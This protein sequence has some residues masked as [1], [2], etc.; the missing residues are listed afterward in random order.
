MAYQPHL[1]TEIGRRR[2]LRAILLAAFA[3]LA[4]ACQA[5]PAEPDQDALV[6]EPG[7]DSYAIIQAAVNGL[8]GTTVVLAADVFV[9]DSSI[10]IEHGP[11]GSLQKD[12][13][14]GRNYYRPTRLRLVL[15]GGDCVL[16]NE[17]DGTRE[18]LKTLSCRPQ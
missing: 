12:A 14:G 6:A 2:S 9:N 1:S 3:L 15:S 8:L 13:A 16:I 11:R 10:A 4:S 18:L 17:S 7:A 5:I